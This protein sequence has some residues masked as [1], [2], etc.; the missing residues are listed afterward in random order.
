MNVFASIDTLEFVKSGE[1]EIE[2]FD[3]DWIRLNIEKADPELIDQYLDAVLQFIR[4]TVNARIRI[5]K[6]ATNVIFNLP[7]CF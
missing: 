1:V 3:Q 7:Y 4:K 2:D 6:C 5:L